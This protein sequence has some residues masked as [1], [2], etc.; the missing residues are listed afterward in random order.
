MVLTEGASSVSAGIKQ[1]VSKTDLSQKD[2][3]NLAALERRLACIAQPLNHCMIMSN[4]SDERL[5]SLLEKPVEQSLQLLQEIT[6][7]I[8]RVNRTANYVFDEAFSLELEFYKSELDFLLNSL[9]LGFQLS[10]EE[11]AHMGKE[12]ISMTAFLKS[13]HRLRSMSLI[14]GYTL[15]H[16]GKLKIKVSPENPKVHPA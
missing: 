5:N 15:S 7:F 8:S 9:E 4:G 10:K 1:L 14:S 11:R 13:S 16:K 6:A 2:K 12:A 3:M